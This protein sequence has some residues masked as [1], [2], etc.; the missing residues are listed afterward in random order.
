M[1]H[2]CFI[3]F[4]K[5]DLEFKDKL[6][7]KFE[8]SEVIDKTLDKEII[9]DDGE[10]IMKVIRKNYL[11]DSTVTIFLIGEHSSE[12]EGKDFWGL[13]KNYFIQKEL[14][15]SLYNGEENTRNGLIGVVLPNMYNKI[16]KGDAICSKCNGIHRIL[17][18]NDDTVI[19]EFSMNYFIKPNEK[20]YWSEED[21]Y[22]ILVKWEDF[23]DSPEIYIDKAFEKRSHPI[24]NKVKIYRLRE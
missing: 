24:A 7:K 22:A 17:E 16:Y 4:K 23:Y 12:K 15:A 10:Y 11:K 13:E 5:E 20:C 6:V 9:S 1:G 21:R 2:K 19:R 14:Q 18:M 8:E 3:S